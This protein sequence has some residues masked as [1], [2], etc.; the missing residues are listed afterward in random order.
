MY[1][2]T[3]D[4]QE[5]LHGEDQEALDDQGEPAN[6]EWDGCG[7]LLLMNDIMP[8]VGPK[9]CLTSHAISQSKYLMTVTKEQKMQFQVFAD[10]VLTGG[11]KKSRVPAGHLVRAR[12]FADPKQITQ[13]MQTIMA[14]RRT[15]EPDDRKKLSKDQRTKFY[16][17]ARS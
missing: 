4:E 7:F 15:A 12:N 16:S 11:C 6:K 8:S 5:R 13:K 10:I 14:R 17:A 3:F 2:W 9:N 1:D